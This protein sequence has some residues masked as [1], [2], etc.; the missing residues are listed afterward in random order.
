MK[1][2][3]HRGLGRQLVLNSFAIGVYNLVYLVIGLWYARY[4]VNTLGI[5]MQAV[6]PVAASFVAYIQFATTTVSGSVGRFAHTIDA[7]LSCFF[8][9]RLPVR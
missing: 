8:G 4:L 3:A 2:V 9:T 7:L 1:P 6:V 5:A